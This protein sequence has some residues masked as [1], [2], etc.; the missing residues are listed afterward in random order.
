MSVAA[1]EQAAVV[2]V[3][4]LV[5]ILAIVIGLSG[6]LAPALLAGG[7]AL[8]LLASLGA[9][10]ARYRLIPEVET[11][12]KVR[13]EIRHLKREART[14]GKDLQRLGDE[15]IRL[16]QAESA[17]LQRV[18]GLTQAQYMLDQL[19]RFRLAD[20][21]IPGIGV[22]LRDR[23]AAAGVESAA[24][25]ELGRI[26]NVA[27]I[28]EARANRLLDWR[29]AIE[30]SLRA[31]LVHGFSAAKV[32]QEMA[33][34]THYDKQRL[35]I[36]PLHKAAEKQLAR[37]QKDLAREQQALAAYRDVTFPAYLRLVLEKYLTGGGP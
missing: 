29:A 7:M 14:A 18:R 30:N 33:I 8:G 17:E 23:L 13:A 31:R 24:D 25:V 15:L 34:R 4:V 19:R 32:T 27:G 16:N 35:S 26:Q 21:D 6:G 22:G 2:R 37:A 36:G 28:G 5:A 12:R 20:A 9:L 1:A 3:F 11:R 10:A